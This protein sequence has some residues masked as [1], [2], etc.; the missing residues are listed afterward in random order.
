[1][2]KHHKEQTVNNAANAMGD[3][4][5]ALINR[6]KSLLDLAYEAGYN[7]AIKDATERQPSI[8]MSEQW[9]NP[10]IVKPVDLNKGCQVCGIGADGKPY[11][12]VCNRDDCPTRVTC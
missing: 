11:G 4:G 3:V 9:W 6:I 8:P 10:R 1:M 12:Y 2:N 5:S 7:Q